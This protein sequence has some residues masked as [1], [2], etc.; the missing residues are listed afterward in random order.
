MSHGMRV[1]FSVIGCKA[2][3]LPSAFPLTTSDT[4][5]AFVY[6]E[7]YEQVVIWEQCVGR[8]SFSYGIEKTKVINPCPSLPAI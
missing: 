6:L 8:E 5:G 7:N 3:Q 4:L 1:Q 2:V